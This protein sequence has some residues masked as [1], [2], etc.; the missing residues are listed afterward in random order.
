MN[1]QPAH[2]LFRGPTALTSLLHLS[3]FSSYFLQITSHVFSA[4]LSGR[5]RGKYYFIFPEADCY[6]RSSYVE[7][8]LIDLTPA[9]ALD[10]HHLT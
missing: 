6:Y 3:S 2:A 10:S 4:V 8:E 9:F 5:N 7:T 1:T